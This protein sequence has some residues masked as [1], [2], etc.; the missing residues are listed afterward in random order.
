MNTYYAASR[1]IAREILHVIFFVSRG[2]PSDVIDEDIRARV[3]TIH[4]MLR[5]ARD[6]AL[7][8]Q[9]HPLLGEYN[10][11]S[12]SYFLRFFPADGKGVMTIV[13]PTQDSESLQFL[14]ALG[15]A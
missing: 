1:S 2:A 13:R 10:A 15:K 12:S 3:D 14:E 11:P 4:A 6:Q 9:G 8:R 7:I 5:L